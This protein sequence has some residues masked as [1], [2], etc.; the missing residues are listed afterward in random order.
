MNRND[1][2]WCNSGKKYKKCHMDFD[3][4]L[5]DLKR[6]GFIVPNKDIIKT[7]EQIEGI[8]ASAAINNAV[9]DEVAKHIKAG[10]N[11]EEID[12][13]VYN[14]T[15]S[16]GAIPAP[17]NY[18]GYP[19]SVCTSLNDEVCHG[20]P[21]E[22]IILKEGDILNVDVSTIY[23]GY[24]SDASRMFIIGDAEEHAVHLVNTA[25]EALLKGIE[26]AKPWGFLGDISYAV[27]SYAESKGYSVVRDFG[28]HGIGLK[29]HE[30]PFV[31]HFGNKGEDMILVPG[32]VFTIEPMINEGTYE[33]VI[34]EDD[35]WTVFTEDGGLSAQ[36]EHMILITE[37]GV[38]ILAK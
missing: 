20:I 10:M 37:T 15:T 3:T 26:A 28:G 25:K 17:L 14:F 11:T 13:I 6:Q 32:M 1:D 12:S 18:Q 31:P 29:F 24:Y 34:D 22:V 16:K 5:A 9:L 30:E 35:E 2:C 33:V 4:R 27:Q 19:K 36:W 21:H 38:E 7:P 8:K 23:N